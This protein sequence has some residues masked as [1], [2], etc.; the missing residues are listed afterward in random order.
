[1][2]AITT[3]GLTKRYNGTVAVENLDLT[4]ERNEVFGFVGPNGAGKSST[5]AILI[6]HRRPSRGTATVLDHPIDGDPRAIRSRVGVLPERCGL[7]DRLTAREH[8][9]AAIDLHGSDDDPDVLLARVD[10]VADGDRRTQ[11]YSTGMAQRLRLALALVGSPDLLILDEPA[12]GLDPSGIKLLRENVRAERARGTTVFFS[13]HS[14]AD[15]AALSDRVGF[16][17]GGRLE[18]VVDPDEIDES[19]GERFDRL[20]R[21]AR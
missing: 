7:F 14:L 8:L 5:I 19:L 17:I 2:T 16:L 11:T 21:E 18:S 9:A 12:A 10:L 3:S 13:S 15:V 6:G 4:V 20:V 1:M